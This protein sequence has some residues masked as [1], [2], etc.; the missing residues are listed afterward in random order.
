MKT[1]TRIARRASSNA[2]L[3]LVALTLALG[4]TMISI[5][6][7][8]ADRLCGDRLVKIGGP[9]DSGSGCLDKPNSLVAKDTGDKLDKGEE[10]RLAKS[11]HSTMY[12]DGPMHK[13][14]PLGV[15][16]L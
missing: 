16:T 12:K 2:T 9:A 7:T 1:L 5:N 4:G 14:D 8:P 11:D 13:D 6:A 10:C 3:G 15:G